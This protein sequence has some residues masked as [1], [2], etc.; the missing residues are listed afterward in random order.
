MQLPDGSLAAC[1]S[2]S[3]F[4]ASSRPDS[5]ERSTH[6]SPRCGPRGAGNCPELNRVSSLRG[7][8]TALKQALRVVPLSARF[9]QSAENSRVLVLGSIW[10]IP[11]LRTSGRGLSAV[12][13]PLS[14]SFP[15]PVCFGARE[16][17]EIGCGGCSPHVFLECR[18]Q[19]GA[20][21]NAP[22]VSKMPL[23]PPPEGT[24]T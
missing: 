6:G 15:P 19:C 22:A 12:E 2:R 11:L 13:I 5:T 1:T 17:P 16:S 23:A 9:L 14:S 21:G 3:P 10:Q 18:C 20:P 7:W 24:G 8:G 4:H